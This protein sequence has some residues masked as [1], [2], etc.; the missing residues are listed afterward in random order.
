MEEKKP[1]NWRKEAQIAKVNQATRIVEIA[2]ARRSGELG[3]DI[4]KLAQIMIL[5]TLPYSEQTER[6]VTRRA[7]LGDGSYLAVTFTAARPDTPLPFGA[8]RKL[9]AWI[10]DRAITS[11]AQFIPWQ[12]AWEYQKEMGTAMGGRANRQMN[13]R[14]HRLSGLIINIQREGDATVQG[15]PY[16]VFAYY[17]LPKSI[18]GK[19]GQAEIQQPV[20]PE[21]AEKQGL[22][23]DDQLFH[24]I[25]KH[26]VVLPRELWQSIK[27]PA[28]VQ[29]IIFWLIYRCYS[30]A[31]ETVVPWSALIQQFPQDS[32]PHR[33]RQNVK[34]A[35]RLLKVLWPGVKLAVDPKGIWLSYTGVP[36]LANDPEKGR[37]RRL[38]A[39]T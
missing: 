35:V 15:A 2:A 39:K 18:V 21:M 9:L 26:H 25:C 4:I 19:L 31:S 27:G 22:Y 37:V 3:E 13:E 29:D 12:S 16:K 38:L 7:R 14:F 32:N 30:A 28:P 36:F 10:L 34:E 23:L 5:T 24:D 20:F 17:N 11:G 33:I 6:Q 8:D 1:R